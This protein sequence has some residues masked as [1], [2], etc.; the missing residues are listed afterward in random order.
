MKCVLWNISGSKKFF[1]N[2]F[3]AKFFQI[4]FFVY[5]KQ[6]YLLLLLIITI[7]II[8]IHIYYYHYFFFFLQPNFMYLF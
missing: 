7:I 8:H 1:G 4:F 5:Y 3:P 6:I 2:G